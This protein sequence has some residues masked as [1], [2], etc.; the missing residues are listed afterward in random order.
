MSSFNK[1]NLLLNKIERRLGTIPLKLPEEVSKDKWA[2]TCIVPDSLIT[3][4]RY[5]P[6]MV[7]ITIDTKDPKNRKGNYF[8]I[9][10]AL[11]GGAEIIGVKDINW[12]LW[13]GS[14]G[15]VQQSGVGYYDYLSSYNNYSMDDVSLLQVRADL[16]S[17]FNN[18]VFVDFKE[19]NLIRLQSATHGEIQDGFGEIPLDVFVTHPANLMTI[20]P[21]SMG[22]FEDLATADV[23]VFLTAYL[24]HYE[25]LETVFASVDMKLNYMES[26]AN[27]R[28]EI[29]NTLENSY[30]NPANKNQPIMYCV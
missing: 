1:M 23:A 4:S 21:T 12:S 22:I 26:W 13:G 2:E 11:V 10:P 20:S 17:I 14:G 29:I 15:M 8:I 28:D 5:Y 25:G 9:D 6:H 27:K 30:V 16:T 19:P 18:S 3:F 7:T 24:Q